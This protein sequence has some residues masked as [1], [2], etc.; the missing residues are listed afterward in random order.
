MDKLN[1]GDK[2][3]VTIEEVKVI[4]QKE[5]EIGITR[6]GLLVRCNSRQAGKES[7]QKRCGNIVLVV[8]FENSHKPCANCATTSSSSGSLTKGECAACYNCAAHYKLSRPQAQFSKPAV[9]PRS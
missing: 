5:A 2:T 7:L 3:R 6:T 9:S 4:S 8:C 1:I